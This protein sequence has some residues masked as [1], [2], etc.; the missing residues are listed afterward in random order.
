[1][2]FSQIPVCGTDRGVVVVVVVV[3]VA[4][5]V[6]EELWTVKVTEAV[7]ILPAVSVALAVAVLLPDD[8]LLDGTHDQFPALSAVTAPV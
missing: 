5:E 2:V 4:F 7:V 8:R 6:V 1:M 3:V